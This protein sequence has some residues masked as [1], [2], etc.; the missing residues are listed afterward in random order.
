MLCDA[1]RR[2]FPALTLHRAG[3]RSDG[4]IGFHILKHVSTFHGSMGDSQS[5]S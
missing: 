1:T 2:K 3:S 4:E 5:P